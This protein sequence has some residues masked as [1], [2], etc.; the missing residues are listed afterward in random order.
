MVSPSVQILTTEQ[1]I[2]ILNRLEDIE[3]RAI[4]ILGIFRDP[5]KIDEA[6][7]SYSNMLL[8]VQIQ[9]RDFRVLLSKNNGHWNSDIYQKFLAYSSNT[10]NHCNQAAS[11][12]YP[13]MYRQQ[14]RQF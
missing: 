6:F 13:P 9:I 5:L 8:E 14:Q 1:M 4:H 7:C 11:R 12:M 10:L 2:E 3:L